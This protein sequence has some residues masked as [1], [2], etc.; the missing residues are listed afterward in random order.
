MN[1]TDLPTFKTTEEGSRL[2]KTQVVKQLCTKS[3]TN[4]YLSQ[5]TFEININAQTR[6]TT[7]G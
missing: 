3:C 7:F 5:A 4:K 2:I 6:C 1:I